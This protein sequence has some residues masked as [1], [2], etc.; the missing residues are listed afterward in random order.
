MKNLQIVFVDSA[1]EDWQSL[2]AGVKPGIEV[3]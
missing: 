3:I 1:V 2:A